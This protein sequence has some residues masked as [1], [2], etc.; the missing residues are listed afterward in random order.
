M[1][2]I[3]LLLPPVKNK[4]KKTLELVNMLLYFFMSLFNL[5]HGYSSAVKCPFYQLG[6]LA[7]VKVSPPK[8][9]KELAVIL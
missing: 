3:M 4:Q 7:K 2:E 1:Q 9:E 5:F 6:L 8:T